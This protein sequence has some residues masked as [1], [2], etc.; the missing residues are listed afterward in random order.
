MKMVKGS[1]DHT[2]ENAHNNLKIFTYDNLRSATRNFRPSAMLGVSDGESVYKGWL[3]GSSLEPSI[4]GVGIA[5][6]IKISNT[7]NAQRLK[8]WQAEVN[9]GKLSHP[10]LV[11]LLGYYS[12]DRMLCL[13]YDHIPKR[14]LVN[15]LYRHPLQWDTTMKIATGIAQGLAFLHTAG[16]SPVNRTFNPSNVLL[17]GDFEPQ[18]Y[19]GSASLFRAHGALPVSMSDAVTSHYIPPEYIATGHWSV[20]SDVYAFGVMLLDMIAGSHFLDGYSDRPQH[21]LIE[22]AR[23]VLSDT[24]K[25]QRIMDPWLEHGNPPKGASKAAKLILSCLEIDPEIRPSMKKVM[26]SLEEI[27]VC[28]DVAE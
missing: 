25:L 24:K 23:P 6:P 4:S 11:K 17:N 1:S 22:W 5:V 27:K 14:N 13:V 3:D 15:L 2:K 19:F 18:L 16:D 12:E 28:Q 26:T 21:S 8:E 9:R 20:K 7:D 10:N